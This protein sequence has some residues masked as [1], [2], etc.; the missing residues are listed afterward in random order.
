MK[1]TVTERMELDS[2]AD[3]FTAGDTEK[4]V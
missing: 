2:R 3:F 1:V 4:L